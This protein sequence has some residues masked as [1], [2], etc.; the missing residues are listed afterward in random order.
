MVK[1][2]VTQLQI[3]VPSAK[4]NIIFSRKSVFLFTKTSFVCV[5]IPN[6]HEWLLQ[7]CVFYIPLGSGT[8]STQY[9]IYEVLFPTSTRWR[10]HSSEIMQC[11]ALERCRGFDKGLR[12]RFPHRIP[13]YICA[14][15]TAKSDKLRR[16]AQAGRDDSSLPQFLSLPSALML[17]SSQVFFPKVSLE[18]ETFTSTLHTSAS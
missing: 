11:L 6:V 12:S 14:T 8:E 3:G 2:P 16:N 17:T 4:K 1:N 5:C 10:G 7:K 18:S 15:W 13:L 9:L